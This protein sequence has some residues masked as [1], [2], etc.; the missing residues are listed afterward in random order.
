MAAAIRSAVGQRSGSL[1]MRAGAPAAMR[2]ASSKSFFPNEPEAPTV[3]SAVP[4]PN[5]N[6]AI[7]EL[8]QVFDTRSVNFLSDYSKSIGNYIADPD[9]NMMLDV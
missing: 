2:F 7:A 1:A 5:G 4:G 3:K 8:E 6:K 9:G